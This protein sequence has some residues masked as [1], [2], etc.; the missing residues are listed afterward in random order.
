MQRVHAKAPGAWDVAQYEQTFESLWQRHV[1]E[2]LKTL[3]REEIHASTYRDFE[4]LRDRMEEFIE[5]YYNVCRLHSA[6]DYRS[7]ESFE[8]QRLV[9]S[10]R[11]SAAAIMNVLRRLKGI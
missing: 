9:E 5:G 1:R 8:K 10:Q 6:L 3:K 11:R 4:D 7:P 2:L